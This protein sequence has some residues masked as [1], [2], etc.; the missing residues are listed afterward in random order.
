[1]ET[2]RP[3]WIEKIKK[4]ALAKFDSLPLP[5][6][7]FI[8]LSKFTKNEKVLPKINSIEDAPKEITDLFDKLGISKEERKVFL[9][10]SVQAD[11]EVIYNQI[12][13]VLLKKGI[14]IEG[15]DEAVK[16][17]DW[18]KDYFF[19]LI[20]YD[21]DK[22]T[23]YHAANWRNGV[24]LWAKG[25]YKQ[26]INA[27][28]MLLSPLFSQLEHTIV[29]AEPNSEVSL[30]EGCTAPIIRNY[31]LHIGVNE[32][33]VKK[34]AKVTLTKLQNWPK[35]VHTRP[36]TKVLVEE[37]ATFNMVNVIF[38]GGASTIE[39][40]VIELKGKNSKATIETIIFSPEESLIRTGT[41]VLNNGKNSASLLP[42]KS[43]LSGKSR[44]SIKDV[45]K[46]NNVSKGHISC[47]ALLL[48]ENAEIETYPGLYSSNKNASLSHEA[49]IG[50]L[51][52][53][54]LFY[55][56]SRGLNEENAKSVLIKGFV[57]PIL[58]NIPFQYQV[59]ISKMLNILAEGSM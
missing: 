53:E 49:S 50:K 19:K 51:N 30:V 59:E 6:G 47:D 32:I 21:Q 22:L 29:I 33:Y 16:R 15:M 17:Y 37:N 13:D 52:E 57:E 38:G 4:D 27:D 54:S 2:S 45:I 11:N 39:H 56:M 20:N 42:S 31:S 55:L 41:T 58:R 24:F 26:P 5:K 28:F 14:I 18:L 40:P 44:V 35:Y 34:N 48:S 36:I 1:M 25:V 7:D 23:A 9:G 3:D 12:K 8:D 43:I 10:L 46:A